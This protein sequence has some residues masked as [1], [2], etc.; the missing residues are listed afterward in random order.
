MNLATYLQKTRFFLRDAL[1]TAYSQQ[2][3]IDLINQAR[4]DV[5]MDTFCC[6]ALV[7]IQTVAGQD[8]YTF[9]TVL[10]AVQAQG[11]A[12][13]QILQI[14]SISTFW[15]S[16]LVPMMDYLEWEDLSAF[17]RSFRGYTFIPFAWGMF[18]LQSFF[19]EPI[20][21]QVYTLEIDCT[22]LPTL[23]VNLND[24]ETVIPPGLADYTLIPWLAASHAKYN[25]NAYGASERLF[26][27]YATELEKRMGCFPAYRVPSRYGSD[28]RRP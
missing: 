17:Y 28:P 11:N 4:A 20:P 6:R 21:N 12:A 22:Y 23:M 26:L 18:D 2:D 27:K 25:Q 3:L 10:Q 13:V 16:N 24:Q 8:K 15:S 1:G 14:N 7:Q 9:N 19:V 5:I